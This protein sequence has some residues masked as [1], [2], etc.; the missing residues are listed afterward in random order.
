MNFYRTQNGIYFSGRVSDLIAML[1]DQGLVFSTV[2]E[3]I[4][5][6]LH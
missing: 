2:R 5:A 1:R 4:R 6:G 3:F